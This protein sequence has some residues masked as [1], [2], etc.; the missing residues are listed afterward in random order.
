MV[1]FDSQDGKERPL[2]Y[3]AFTLLPKSLLDE[4]PSH[5]KDVMGTTVHV[6]PSIMPFGQFAAKMGDRLRRGMIVVPA[7][8]GLGWPALVTDR[9]LVFVSDCPEEETWAR[10]ATLDIGPDDVAVG[11]FDT[12]A[13]KNL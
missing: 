8:M 12:E 13:W 5:A 4:I 6:L 10:L 2:A 9:N 1:A 11:P 3:V 7:L